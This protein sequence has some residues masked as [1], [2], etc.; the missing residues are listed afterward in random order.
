MYEWDPGKAKANLV[1]HGVM[2]ETARAFDWRT[3]LVRFD[4]AHSRDERRYVAV[5]YIGER[6]YV[7]VFTPRRAALRIIGLR[8]AND[9]EKKHYEE[10]IEASG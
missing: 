10:K 3:A 1:K 8:K 7:M 6:L 5:G 4:A 9:R 2:F